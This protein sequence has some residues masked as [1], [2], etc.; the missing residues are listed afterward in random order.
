MMVIKKKPQQRLTRGVQQCR[1]AGMNTSL[2]CL[3]EMYKLHCPV[4]SRKSNSTWGVSLYVV[5][6][7]GSNLP[8]KWVS[9]QTKENSVGFNAEMC[10]WSAVLE[11]N[12]SGF[13][14]V[15]SLADKNKPQSPNNNSQKVWHYRI[16]GWLELE[17]TLKMISFQPRCYGQG[18]LPP[19]CIIAYFSC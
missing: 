13:S 18:Y 6:I 2:C 4:S 10:Y 12:S 14:S 3:R 17:E 11:H 15:I 19:G 8:V 9:S 7:I 16:I 5:Y 1:D